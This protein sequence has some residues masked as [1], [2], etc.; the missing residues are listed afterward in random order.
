LNC[1]RMPLISLFIYLITSLSLRLRKVSSS[2]MYWR[3]VES[4]MRS[5]ELHGEYTDTSFLKI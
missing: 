5:G 2:W 1:L 4:W 3:I